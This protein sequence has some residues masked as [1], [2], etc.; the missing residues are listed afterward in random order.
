VHDLLRR[1]FPGVNHK[2]GLTRA[3]I[4]HHR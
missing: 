4:D 3:D 2:R 1:D